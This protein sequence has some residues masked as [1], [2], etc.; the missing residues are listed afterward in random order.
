M[1]GARAWLAVVV[2][3]VVGGCHSASSGPA[4]NGTMCAVNVDCPSDQF[5][6]SGI[7]AH[8]GVTMTGGACTATRDCA[9]G[10]FCDGGGQCAPGG[11]LK[12][13]DSCAADA[14]CAPPLRCNLS[15]FFGVCGA[16][17]TAESGATCATAADCLA[18]LVCSPAKTC[19]PPAEA[20]PPFQ[21]VKCADE[22]PFR[23]YFEVPR[24]GNP[25]KDFYRLPFPN[26][27]R[28]NAGA[29][30]MTDFPKPG[31]TPLGIDLVQLYV[32][33][34][35]NDFDGFSAIGVTTFRYSGDIDYGTSTGDNVW[36]VDLTAG[37]TFGRQYSRDWLFTPDRT[38][39]SCQH[40]MTVR[41]TAAQ[42]LLPSHTYGVI[43]STGI[44]SKNGET[45]M[46]D[47]DLVALLAATAPADTTLMHAWQ[48]YQPLRDWLANPGQGVTAPSVATAAVF[49]VQDAPGHMQRLAASVAQQPPPV[50]KDLTLCDTGVKS[51][52]DDGTPARACPAADPAFAEI[53]GRFSVP[54]YQK[55][56]EP[57]DTPADGGGIVEMNGAPQVDRTEDV[58]FVLTVPRVPAPKGGWPLL[59]YHHGTGGSMRSVVDD[60]LAKVLAT[61]NAPSTTFGF[62]AV[63]HGARV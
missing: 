28:V 44:K 49:T 20:Y 50:L 5:C 52:C 58:C 46:L 16:G 39:Y 12:A 30:D 55:G 22:G 10:L 54:I 40:R 17:G 26:D 43:L 61:A 60:G 19:L 33:A 37:P 18:G 29:L 8:P 24:A 38:K 31:P 48:A 42:P 62:D 51:P 59:V 23:V 57:Y 15:G 47:P 63:E 2:V 1:H 9:D 36:L 32:D 13:G 27:V 11:S 35:V 41:N 45:A 6:V 7:C 25:P 4:S 14:V 21:G 56:T 3:S 53:H 34:W